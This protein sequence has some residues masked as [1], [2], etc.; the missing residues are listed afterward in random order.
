MENFLLVNIINLTHSFPIH[1]FYTV[2][3][4]SE[5]CE[6]FLCFQGVEKGCTGNK[7]V[8]MHFATFIKALAESLSQNSD[9]NYSHLSSCRHSYSCLVHYIFSVLLL[10]F[11]LIINRSRFLWKWIFN[12][13]IKWGLNNLKDFL[14][15]EK[16]SCLESHCIRYIIPEKPLPF[17]FPILW[18]LERE[19]ETFFLLLIL[20]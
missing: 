17:A 9:I 11:L 15:L 4:T 12:W 14:R 2:L 1:P 19:V 8:N 16:D 10:L 18:H 13:L 7:C 6:V 3:E 5:N 20:L